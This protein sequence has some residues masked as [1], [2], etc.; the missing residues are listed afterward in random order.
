MQLSNFLNAIYR[1]LAYFFSLNCTIQNK[2]EQTRT[3]KKLN[4]TNK[5]HHLGTKSFTLVLRKLY[6]FEGIFHRFFKW[7][8]SRQKFKI[9][10]GKLSS[11]LYLLVFK[12]TS[13]DKWI[14]IVLRFETL[15]NCE[16][17]KKSAIYHFLL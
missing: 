9:N 10:G 8:Y 12:Y 3:N 17:C 2:H 16:K 7:E 13:E 11:L 1:Q 5:C 14:W 4:F 6:P 15:F